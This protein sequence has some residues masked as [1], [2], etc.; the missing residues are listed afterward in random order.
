MTASIIPQ[1]WLPATQASITTTR[2]SIRRVNTLTR[3]ARVTRIVHTLAARGASLFR[4]LHHARSQRAASNSADRRP[5]RH[6]PRAAGQARDHQT[7]HACAISQKHKERGLEFASSARYCAPGSSGHRSDERLGAAGEEGR[8]A[9]SFAGRCCSRS[10]AR[11]LRQ[12]AT[13]RFCSSVSPRLLRRSELADTRGRRRRLLQRG[14][15][16]R[17]SAL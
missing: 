17:H 6:A 9:R 15:A 5:L 12:N 1:T 3:R 13:A 14:P 11:A 7:A 2:R 4:L 16:S 10:A 8:Y